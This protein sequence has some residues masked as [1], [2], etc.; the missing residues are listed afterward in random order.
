VI[1][2]ESSVSEAAV[3]ATPPLD[4]RG[5]SPTAER[6]AP[7]LLERCTD[8]LNRRIASE[9]FQHWAATFP[10][11]R[12]IARRRSRALFDIMAGF[13]YTQTIQSCVRLELFELLAAGPLT[14]SAIAARTQLPMEGAE[15]LL[16]AAA[17]LQLVERRRDDWWA[18]GQRAAPLVNN[19]GLR[20]LI[21]HHAMVYRDLADPVALLRKTTADHP[22][23]VRDFFPYGDVPQPQA[24][25]TE[26]VTPYSRMMSDTLPPLALDILDSYDLSAHHT[27][28]DVGGGEG[29]F[30]GF[31]LERHAGLRGQLFDLPAVTELADA[32][33]RRLGLRDRV[34]LV[35]GNF[36]VDPV[37][38]GADVISLV[39]VCLDHDDAAVLRL[40]TRIH[41]ALPKG[42][43]LLIAE[44]MA[45][46]RGAEPVG[47]AYFQFYL[48]AMGRGRARRPAEL[49]EMLRKAGFRRSREHRTRYP[50]Q[51]GL[52][53][54]EA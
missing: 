15:R 18:L 34:A 9:S 10:L 5:A 54:A 32:R 11:T 49:H 40:L 12:G 24:F 38:T 52:I 43:T 3:A 6:W 29:T 19:T 51:T 50:V 39:R 17:S 22:T 35:G 42:G 41:R 8:W 14:T 31:A 36:H 45:G 16:K 20:A 1:I 37:P 44:A 28:L 21:H 47:D 7:T 27:L 48:L 46:A 53:S 13:V 26:R 23:E 33:L 2:P 30:L 25:G 4:A